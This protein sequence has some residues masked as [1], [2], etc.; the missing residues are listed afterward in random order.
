MCQF[1]K[2]NHHQHALQRVKTI[3]GMYRLNPAS[4]CVAAYSI[5]ERESVQL[6]AESCSNITTY[7]TCTHGGH[8]MLQLAP[9][10]GSLEYTIHCN[11]TDQYVSA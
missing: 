10:S 6:F 1:M 7:S 2:E 11:S 9:C 3:L 5:D 8:Q 4:F